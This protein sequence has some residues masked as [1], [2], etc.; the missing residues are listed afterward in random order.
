MVEILTVSIMNSE[1]Q[2]VFP[3]VNSPFETDDYY[4]ILIINLAEAIPAGI[5][6]ITITYLGKINENPIDRGFYKGYYY[7]GDIRR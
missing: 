7:D 6:K 3:N 1:N 2:P 4:E 5:Y